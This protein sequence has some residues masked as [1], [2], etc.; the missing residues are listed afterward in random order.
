MKLN[1]YFRGNRN[2]KNIALTFDDGPHPIYTV[3]IMNLL[4]KHN[5]KA[6]FFV[7]GKYIDKNPDIL[8][9]LFK[10]DHEIGNHGYSHRNLI[11][12]RI[13]F[14][15][16]EITHT[17]KLIEK[18]CGFE[19]DLVRPPYLRLDIFSCIAFKRLKKKIIMGNL[20]SHDYKSTNAEKL[21]EK[22]LKKVKNG[23]I[24]IFH[25]GGGDRQ[26]TLDA[27]K[28]IIPKLI[29]KGYNFKKISEMI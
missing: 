12:K 22:I 28:I 9:K 29:E 20:S 23:S 11:F 26:V 1:I 19:T 24:L 13:D 8:M 27:L 14:V 21:A 5:M 2:Q 18:I 6:T 15:K 7:N 4:K 3:K 17:D 16:D 10:E 25:D